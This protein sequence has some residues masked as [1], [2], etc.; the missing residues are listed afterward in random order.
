MSKVEADK[1]SALESAFALQEPG[2]STMYGAQW[3][4]DCR[5]TE[6]VFK[7][8]GVPLSKI[9]IEED[10]AARE[11][12][13]AING[14]QQIIPVVVFDG[15]VLVEPPPSAVEAAIKGQL[16]STQPEK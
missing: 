15:F 12:V 2:V 3:C 11:L 7:S 13:L 4:G 16:S 5:R 8:L 9:D 14:G 1:I 6:R 10:E